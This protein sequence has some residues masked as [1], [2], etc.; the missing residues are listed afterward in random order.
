MAFITGGSRGIGRATA[1]RLTA[2]RPAHI[3]IGY[4][5]DHD[6]ARNTVS[7]IQQLGV[8]ASAHCADV[9]DE[10]AFR[11]VFRKLEDRHGRLDLLISA[12]AR[13]SFGPLMEVSPRSWQ[14][15]MDLNARA[16]LLGA[17]LAAPLMVD[18][19]RILGISSLGGRACLEDYG[20]LGVA[21]A[22][23]ESLT[24]YLA[25]ELSGRSIRVNSVCGGFVDT[26]STRMLPEFDQVASVIAT[27]TPAARVGRPEDI[28][29]VL[30]F[31]CSSDSD[32]ITGQTIVAD[33]GLS[34]RL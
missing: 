32:W 21:K 33:G 4:V 9:S 30:A 8:P 17:Q 27:R 20:L 5:L 23:I 34:L 12:A 2:H 19:G 13:A 25:V 10:A 28:A 11:D 16:F 24:R 18:G 3:A 1:L 26:D 22:A 31:L 7:E 15:V 14:R 29:A 6:A